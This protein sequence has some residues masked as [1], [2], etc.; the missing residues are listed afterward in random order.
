MTRQLFLLLTSVFVWFN[1]IAQERITTPE[2]FKL[3]WLKKTANAKTQQA[4]DYLY[5]HG[6]IKDGET[7]VRSSRA[8]GAE[9]VFQLPET[10][11]GQEMT[12]VESALRLMAPGDSVT[13]RIGID[14]EQKQAMGFTNDTMSFDVVFVRLETKAEHE[15]VIKKSLEKEAEIAAN[16]QTTAEQFR[17]GKLKDKLQ[18]TASGLKYLIHE[19]GNGNLPKTGSNVQ[20][21]YY[22][23]LEDGTAFDNSFS[24]G[25]PIAFSLG[26]GQVIPGWDEGIALLKVG[27]KATLF[28][29]ASLAYGEQG[30]PPTIPG[31][32]LLV[33]YVE[34][35]SAR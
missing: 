19:E 33:F 2:G 35:L 3:V 14:P 29:P 20:V 26:V 21:H 30:S 28:I 17:T 15:A 1:A 7:V 31:G 10:N 8:E 27:S 6:Y 32:A 12:P 11:A 25:E 22:G 5:F 34:L 9:P 24:R 16:I 23:I 18:T 13:L 4:G